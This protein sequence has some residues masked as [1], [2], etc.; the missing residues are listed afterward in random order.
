M[1]KELK[2]HYMNGQSEYYHNYNLPITNHHH[3]D[4]QQYSDIAIIHQIYKQ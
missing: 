1:N 3:A 2:Q 4:I